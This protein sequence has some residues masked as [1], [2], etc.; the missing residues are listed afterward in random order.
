MTSD[1]NEFISAEEAGKILGIC[2]QVVLKWA[3]LG[4]IPV[5]RFNKRVVRFSRSELSAWMKKY[6]EQPS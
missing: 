6:H 5:Y 4:K 2:A 1:S 3:K